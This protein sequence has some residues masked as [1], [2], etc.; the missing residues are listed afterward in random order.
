MISS[1]VEKTCELFLHHSQMKYTDKTWRVNILSPPLVAVNCRVPLCVRVFSI[2]DRYRLY[3]GPKYMYFFLQQTSV[4]ENLCN[5]YAHCF[6]EGYQMPA[7][8]LWKQ[9]MVNLP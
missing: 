8:S 7:K 2:C 1:A 3:T 4:R 9:L 6:C 5:F